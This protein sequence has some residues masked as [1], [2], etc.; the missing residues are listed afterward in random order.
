[1][2]NYEK[3]IRQARIEERYNIL[4]YLK[5][6]F[7]KRVAIYTEV[8]NIYSSSGLAIKKTIEKRKERKVN[9]AEYQKINGSRIVIN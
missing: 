2:V 6:R 5:F 4:N 1:M 3:L 7:N 9:F 8:K